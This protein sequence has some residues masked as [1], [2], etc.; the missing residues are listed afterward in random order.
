[1]S[2]TVDVYR[3]NGEPLQSVFDYALYI[4]MFPQLIAGPIVRYKEI[5]KQLHDRSP[6][7]GF[8][9]RIVGFLR[10]SIGLGKKVLI[11]NVLAEQVDLIFAV[12]PDFFSSTTAWVGLLAYS[13]QIY[14]DF[15]GYSDMALGIGKMLGYQFPENFNFP[16]I[17]QNIS[18]FWRRWHMTLGNWMKDYLYI[19][20]G[21]NR[22]KISRVYINLVIVFTLSGFWHGA[23][24][25]FIAWGAY[26]GL[27]LIA[28]RLFLIKWYKKIGKIPSVILTFFFAILGWVLF[29]S[30]S[31]TYAWSFFKKLFAFDNRM[32]EFYFDSR[33]ITILVIA[34]IFSLMG[35]FKKVENL[36]YKIYDKNIS[37]KPL[38]LLSS[39][40]VIIY[41]L[42]GGALLAGGFNPFIYFRF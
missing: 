18:E 10:F 5:E 42:C 8:D 2:Y 22:V 7:N 38:L 35:V 15:S 13:F 23:A 29:R 41:L 4:L 12:S 39:I 28:D 31:L 33:F 24:W 27:F 16:Y 36:Q 34:S 32:D 17:S 26:H 11:A 14:F 25:T 1:M 21:G 20:L 6:N 40:A 9:N 37:L 3:K 19:P 30:E